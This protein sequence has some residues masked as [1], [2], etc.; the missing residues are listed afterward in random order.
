M[1]SYY[2]EMPS[3][4]GKLTLVSNENALTH[5]HMDCGEL[6]LPAGA[7]KG[8][9]VL[10][11]TR[12]QLEEYFAGKRVEFDLPMAAQGTE[13][14]RKVWAALYAIPFAET[15]SYIDI[16]RVIGKPK[17]PRAVG[18]ANGRNPIGIIVPCHRVIGANGTLTGYGGGLERKQWL[19]D[20][21]RKVAKRLSRA[22]VK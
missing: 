6:K 8:H 13:F 11:D 1:N 16:A 22:N 9:A 17:G 19:L 4:I 20:H 21:E 15:R 18:M 14:Q 12:R 10:G 5:V 3:P 7:K 2:Q